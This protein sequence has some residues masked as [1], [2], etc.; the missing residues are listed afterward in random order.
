MT[1]GTDRHRIVQV[2]DTHLSRKRAYFHDNW[3][4]FTE[5]MAADPPD[6]IVNSGDLSLDGADDEDDLAFAR[7][8]HDRLAAPW[9]AIPGNHDIGESS[10]AVRLDQPVNAERIARWQRLVGPQWWCRDIGAWRLVGIDTSLMGAAIGE[11]AA[12]WSFLEATL[13][14][15]EGRP[16][17]LFQHMPPYL[18]EPDDPRFTTLAV[19]HAVRGRLLETCLAGGVR[20]I[21]CGHVHA[22]HRQTWKDIEIVWG[23]ATSFFNIEERTRAGFRTPRPGYIEWTLTG[24]SASWKLIEP[25]LMITHDV[26]GWNA[27]VGSTTKLPPRP[28]GWLS[29]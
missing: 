13:S 18:G 5:L 29:G 4:V 19:P 1:T 8:E 10:L 25:P 2:S 26:G 6:L 24:T 11:A 14:A 27:A 21:A 23:P 17:L 7:A 12:Q 3:R 16:V 28:L 9:I 22:H 20:H 15:R